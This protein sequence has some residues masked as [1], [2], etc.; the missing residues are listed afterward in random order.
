MRKGDIGADAAGC[1]VEMVSDEGAIAFE[2]DQIAILKKC[3][4]D[5]NP[6]GWKPVGVAWDAVVARKMAGAL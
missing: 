6:T 4:P 3:S 2:N 1:I 5:E